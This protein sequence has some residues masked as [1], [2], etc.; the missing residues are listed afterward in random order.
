[1]NTQPEY[2]A[3]VHLFANVS[4]G[5]NRIEMSFQKKCI[6]STDVEEG[7]KKTETGFSFYSQSWS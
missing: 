1:M 6:F 5:G 3:L 7:E 4:G 2:I